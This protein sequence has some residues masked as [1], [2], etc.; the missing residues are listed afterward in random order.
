MPI[1]AFP[2]WWEYYKDI[3]MHMTVSAAMVPVGSP[4][5]AVG[6]V[7]FLENT[8]IKNMIEDVKQCHL[9]QAPVGVEFDDECS[10]N[11]GTKASLARVESLADFFNCM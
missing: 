9:D 1:S 4:V 10:G 5:H 8:A 2:E 11:R 3:A 6:V 7:S